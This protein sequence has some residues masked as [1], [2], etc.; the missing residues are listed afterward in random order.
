MQSS[1]RCVGG[2]TLTIKGVAS[3]TCK[4]PIEDGSGASITINVTVPVPLGAGTELVLNV[5]GLVRAG[6]GW[7]GAVF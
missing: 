7:R 3:G 4:V 6:R 5:P 2:T 1:Y